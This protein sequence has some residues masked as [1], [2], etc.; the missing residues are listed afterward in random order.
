MWNTQLARALCSN[1]ASNAI[2]AY[3]HFIY[4]IALFCAIELQSTTNFKYFSVQ[5]VVNALANVCSN[6]LNEIFLVFFFIA[7]QSFFFELHQKMLWEKISEENRYWKLNRKKNNKLKM[8][9]FV[10]TNEDSAFR[11]KKSY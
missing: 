11:L 9:I 5:T 4:I 7:K 1:Y 3:L 6:N 2:R 10:D 8:K